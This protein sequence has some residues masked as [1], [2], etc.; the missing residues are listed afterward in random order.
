MKRIIILISIMLLSIIGF[1]QNFINQNKKDIIRVKGSPD[2]KV[3]VTKE[4]YYIAYKANETKY[5]LYYFDQSEICYIFAVI[6]NYKYLTE[7][8]K[9]LNENYIK[10]NDTTWE[11]YM[12]EG[13]CVAKLTYFESGFSILFTMVYENRVPKPVKTML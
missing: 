13:K 10:L 4:V 1:S 3:D 2:F 5:E 6:D 8:V 11:Y 9:D 7:N 12:K